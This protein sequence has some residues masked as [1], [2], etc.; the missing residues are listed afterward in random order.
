MASDDCVL[1]PVAASP[2]LRETVAYAV[3]AALADGPSRLHFVYVHPSDT[4][5]RLAIESDDAE[6]AE[7]EE[8]RATELLDR[9]RIWATEDAGDREDDLQIGTAQLG[10]DRYIFSPEEVAGLL[11]DEART[12]GCRRVIFDP[13]YDPGIGAPLL[14]PLQSELEQLSGLVVEEAQT[15]RPTRRGP[16]PNVGTPLQAGA[17]FGISFLFYQVL[18][19]SIVL[20]DIVTGAI[21]A[22]I[23]AV[24]LSRVTFASDPTRYAPLRLV[25]L[26]LYVPYL[27]WEIFKAN[28]A[29]S[30]VILHPRLPIDPRLTR[31]RPAVWG[32]LPVTTLA[33][34]ITLTPGT[35][36]VR[37]K[38]QQF[39]V[40]TLIPS[41]R[42]DLFDG[43]LERGV[44]FV[45]YG[46]RA[47]RIA[48]LRDRG[49]TENLQP[50]DGDQTGTGE[51][52]VEETGGGDG[53]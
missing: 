8:D 20:L 53:E 46:R 38:G 16:L 10:A 48:S 3:D 18:A 47:A 30:A 4:T 24:A 37:V 6:S 50:P 32:G 21:S 43:G 42:E 31:I 41:A 13:E 36:T 17:L 22:T 34:S 7:T 51:A 1:V 5:D 14:Q 27:L 23:V 26:G 52:A 45:Y 19:G 44:R 11:A 29:V 35:L 12:A 39:V 15:T 28:V 2:A 25:R 33:N 40:H 9:V 49:E